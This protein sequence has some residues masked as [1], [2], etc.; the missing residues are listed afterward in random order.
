MLTHDDIEAVAGPRGAL[1]AQFLR[2]PKAKET[3]VYETRALIALELFALSLLI[4]A[5]P[6]TLARCAVLLGGL[7]GIDASICAQ[8]T[9][10]GASRKAYAARREIG[11]RP[12]HQQPAW[13]RLK[14][15]EAIEAAAVRGQIHTAAAPVLAL[16]L[17]AALQ[18]GV[19]DAALVG[20]LVALLRASW[21][22]VVYPR[23]RAWWEVVRFL[24][25]AGSR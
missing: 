7:L 15:E 4:I 21:S 17:F 18:G 1:V 5:A 3:N 22:L 12:V 23:W 16:V 6:T 19:T 11:S 24:V 9:R 25:P 14:C 20:A 8:T 2:R 10:S 13:Y